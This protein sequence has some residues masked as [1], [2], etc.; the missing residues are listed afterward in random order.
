MKIKSSSFSYIKYF[1][2]VS[3]GYTVAVTA[4]RLS[5]AALYSLETIVIAQLF[6]DIIRRWKEIKIIDYRDILLI[7]GIWLIKR[8]FEFLY[9]WC[10]VQLV[11]RSN[12]TLPQRILDKKGK[13]S[14]LE[15]ENTDNIQLMRRLGSNPT[16]KFM[17]FL[18]NKL[19]L[20]EILLR[21]LGLLII[22]GSKSPIV[23]MLVA[24]IM[25]PYA[26]I[27]VKNGIIDYEAYE[28]ADEYLRYA[29]Y[30]KEV[31]SD[32]RYVEERTLF[33]Y[34]DYMNERFSKEF[35]ASIASNCKANRTVFIRAGVVDI[36]A[37]LVVGITAASLLYEVHGQGITLGFYISVVKSI[38]NYVQTVSTKFAKTMIKLQRGKLFWEDYISFEK[39]ED[40]KITGEESLPDQEIETIEFKD[41]CFSYPGSEDNVLD[42]IS[43]SLK[44][45]KQYA[46]VGENGAG[47]STIVKLLSGVY[48]NYSGDILINGMNIR[49][50]DEKS[51]RNL[52]SIVPQIQTR[53]EIRLDEYLKVKDKTRTRKVFEELG[54]GFLD[55]DDKEGMR[56][57][58]GHLEKNGIEL[59]GGQ[60][61]LLSIARSA[62]AD[63]PAYILDEPTAA[64][65]PIKEAELYGIFQKLMK[66]KLSILITHRLGAAKS[67]DEIIVLGEGHVL[68]RNNHA[69]LMQQEGLYYK[70]YN[71]QR[72]WYNE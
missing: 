4:L 32:R 16:E 17:E 61:Q 46:L 39:L 67:V 25:I 59:S 70:M 36:M 50:I 30:F 5:I 14:Y 9:D 53:Y 34:S 3:K 12:I 43:F 15:L 23:A 68:E 62:L 40:K 57:Q 19:S 38:I 13:L 48:S 31:I 63:A 2:E 27:S 42:H 51:L 45:K 55:I 44:G 18:E 22:I 49:Q 66:D 10:N 28:E 65:D 60:W 29:D 7:I 69:A 8:G 21:I 54:I 64:I 41:V 24:L 56:T 71:A 37:T 6:D 33:G 35:N 26:T 1:Y 72:T 52:F 47:K 58:L 11:L 20:L